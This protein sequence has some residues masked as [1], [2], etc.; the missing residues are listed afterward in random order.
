MY[1]LLKGLLRIPYIASK[2][3]AL[4]PPEFMVWILELPVALETT[5]NGWPYLLQP[6]EPMDH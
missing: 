2:Q 5:V 3:H 4:T 6:V 1:W